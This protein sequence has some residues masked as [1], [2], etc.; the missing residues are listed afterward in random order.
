VENDGTLERITREVLS[1]HRFDD[2]YPVLNEIKHR[3]RTWFATVYPD[4]F[5]VIVLVVAGQLQI[6]IRKDQPFLASRRN[7]GDIV[8]KAQK[9]SDL[10]LDLQRMGFEITALG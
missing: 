8:L 9:A 4:P 6:G 7:G 3:V 2:G 1:E 10:P 5:I